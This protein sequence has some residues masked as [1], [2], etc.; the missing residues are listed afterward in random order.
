MKNGELFGS[1]ATFITTK[2]GVEYLNQLGF[3]TIAVDLS[4]P[5]PERYKL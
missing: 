4:T 1:S 2:Q 5:E 3:E